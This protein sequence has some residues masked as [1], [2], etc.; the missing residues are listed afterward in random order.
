MLLS[1]LQ[2]C[3]H[4]C[5]QAQRRLP[6][7]ESLAESAEPGARASALRCDQLRVMR[8]LQWYAL[9][10]FALSIYCHVDQLATFKG[11]GC[12]QTGFWGCISQ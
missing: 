4:A 3:L 5:L 6:A 11:I 1:V 7:G 12:M 8:C 9:A 2:T 10:A